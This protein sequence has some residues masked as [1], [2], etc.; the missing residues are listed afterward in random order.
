M[1][2]CFA[3]TNSNSNNKYDTKALHRIVNTI[4]EL[5]NLT[6]CHED[7]LI[8]FISYKTKLSS[9]KFPFNFKSNAKITYYNIIVKCKHS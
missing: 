1:F 6:Y 4:K 9:Y 3:R 2:L 5:N 8:K 7:S